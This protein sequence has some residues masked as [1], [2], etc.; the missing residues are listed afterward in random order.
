GYGWGYPYY[1]G[2]GWGRPNYGWGYGHRAPSCG[3]SYPY[4]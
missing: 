1:G 2:Y 4:Y 3:S